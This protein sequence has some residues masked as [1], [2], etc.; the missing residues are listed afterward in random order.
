MTQVALAVE[1][2]GRI[3]A[4]WTGAV[5]PLFRD[6]RLLLHLHTTALTWT[7]YQILNYWYAFDPQ[8]AVDDVHQRVHLMYRSNYDGIVHRT[9]TD[10]VVSAPVVLGSAV[11]ANPRLAVDPVSGYAYAVWKQSYDWYAYWNGAAWSAPLKKINDW[12]TYY[13]SVAAAPGG[14]VMLAWFQ[15]YITSL[16]DGSG[17]GEPNVPRSAYGDGEPDLF[18]LRQAVSDYYTIPEKDDMLLLTYSAGDG[19]FYLV[20]EHLMYPTH[21]RLYRYTWQSGVWS[22]PLDVVQN[23]SNVAYPVYIGAASDVAKVNYIYNYNLTLQMRAETGG[24]LGASQTLAAYLSARGFSGSPMG[25]FTDHAGD[26]HMTV[27]G[28]KDGVD[29]FY[30]V[31]PLKLSHLSPRCIALAK[32][33]APYSGWMVI[34]SPYGQNRRDPRIKSKAQGKADQAGVGGPFR[35]DP[36]R[37]IHRF[38]RVVQE[39]R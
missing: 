15:R 1:A 24:G 29:G 28:T 27:V 36:G 10:G 25:Y 22:A 14:G 6:F 32:C 2:N 4:L 7:P 9:V 34:K 30:Y 33:N 23:T 12:D 5:E 3:H 39:R 11:A 20:T 35:R 13:T 19:K 16:G 18:P 38:F 37:G 26:L 8:I 21:A 17:P 31:A